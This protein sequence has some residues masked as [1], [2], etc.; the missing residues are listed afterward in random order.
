MEAAAR[1]VLVHV[2]R[3][4]DREGEGRALSDGSRSRGT[5]DLSSA[6]RLCASPLVHEGP[7]QH[8]VRVDVALLVVGG[9]LD[10]RGG[11]A[12]LGR[13]LR[14]AAGVKRYSAGVEGGEGA[15]AMKYRVPMPAV[16][17][18]EGGEAEEAVAVEAEEEGEAREEVLST[19]VA[20]PKSATL[21]C[22]D[23]SRST[24]E[25]LMSRCMT[26]LRWRKAMPAATSLAMRPARQAGRGCG[27]SRSEERVDG[28]SSRSSA[29]EP[30]GSRVWP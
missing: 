9:P 30:S 5:S 27:C 11:G 21:A 12:H 29:L 1:L 3:V 16:W 18:D 26:L 25:G 22:A 4:P 10:Q 8:P 19:S 20:M 17:P 14:G 28:R 23:P 13:L 15:V 24:L 2:A 7:E 6:S